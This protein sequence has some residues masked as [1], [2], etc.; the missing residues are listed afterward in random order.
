MLDLKFDEIDDNHADRIIGA[1]IEMMTAITEAYGEQKGMLVWDE[2]ANQFGDDFKGRVFLAI[3]TG[4]K[5]EYVRVMTGAARAQG[6]FVAL[7]KTIRNYTGWGLKEAKDFADLA[8]TSTQQMKIT[9]GKRADAVRDLR[10]HGAS[11]S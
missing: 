1:G 2:L 8:E 5:S 6:N 11:V 7:I 9:I 10:E 4:R 3:L